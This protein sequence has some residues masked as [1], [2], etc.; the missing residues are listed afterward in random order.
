MTASTNHD[1]PPSAWA[2]YPSCVITFDPLP[3]GVR[4]ELAGE[5][6]AE[7]NR[8]RIMYEIGHAPA[9]YLPHADLRDDLLVSSQHHTHCPFKGGAA[10]W[11]VR[12]GDVTAENA[13]W[14]YSQPY[15]EMAHIAGWF[16]FYWGRFDA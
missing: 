10:Y 15:E 12:V 3:A 8:A 11:H 9:Y 6:V 14:T 16:G 2:L 1:L 4:V 13:V 7:S 5:T